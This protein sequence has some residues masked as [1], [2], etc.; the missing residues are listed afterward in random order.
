VRHAVFVSESQVSDRYKRPFDLVV[1][2]LAHILLLPLWL[3]LWGLL[4][5]AIW[6]TDRGP[7]FY[8]QVRVGLNGRLFRIVKFRTMHVG[9]ERLTGPVWAA[10]D[11]TRVTK[12]GN[13]LRRSRLDE[14]PQIYNILKGDMSLVGPRPERPELVEEFCRLTPNFRNRLSARPGVAGLAQIRGS[15]ATKPSDKLRYDELYIE[16]M[17]PWLDTKLLIL[18]VLVVLRRGRG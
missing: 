2:A 15:Y 17:G 12:I 6:L 8:T 13:F 9:A 14:M 7:I 16:K 4:P 5:L 11:D 1:L 3:V 18:A 10:P